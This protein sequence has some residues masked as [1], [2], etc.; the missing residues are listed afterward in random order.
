MEPAGPGRPAA[1]KKV[2][3][4]SYGKARNR[5]ERDLRLQAK[6]R[7][8]GLPLVLIAWSADAIRRPS[9]MRNWAENAGRTAD[10]PDRGPGDLG[11]RP[12]GAVPVGAGLTRPGPH[13]DM[14]NVKA[15]HQVADRMGCRAQDRERNHPLRFQGIIG[16]MP[17]HCPYRG[18]TGASIRKGASS[19]DGR[20]VLAPRK[21]GRMSKQTA[22]RLPDETHARLKALAAR[23]GRTVS[24]YIRL[25]V[26]EHLEAIED[27]NAAEQALIEHRRSGDRTLSLDE[28]DAELALEN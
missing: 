27:L 9:A 1:M 5:P 10:G 14:R 8:A 17:A 2:N 16:L 12:S 25:A 18:D 13:L 15:L 21:G 24:F 22:V 7:P 6:A 26:E 23:T 11:L 20:G 3:I 28:L 19:S 4:P